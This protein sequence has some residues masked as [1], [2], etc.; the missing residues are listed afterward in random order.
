MLLVRSP[1]CSKQFPIL[2]G[3]LQAVDPTHLTTLMRI[4][5]YVFLKVNMCFHFGQKYF[6]E[7]PE[8]MTAYYLS[9]Y[10]SV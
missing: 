8:R 1:P 2:M 4:C 3:Q 10:R 6:Q 9:V 7:C 5:E